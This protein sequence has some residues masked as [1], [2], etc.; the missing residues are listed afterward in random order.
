[1]NTTQTLHDIIAAALSIPAEQVTD[2]LNYQSIPEWDSVSH[3]YLI[4]ELEA[5]FDITI[6][7]DEVLEMSSVEKVKETL[8]KHNIEI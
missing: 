6:D 4:T 8:R 5:A 7:T 1:M 2:D 3:I